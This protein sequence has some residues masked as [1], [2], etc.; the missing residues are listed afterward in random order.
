MRGNRDSPTMDYTQ[1]LE[2]PGPQAL[3]IKGAEPVDEAPE[4]YL[5]ED[6]PPLQRAFPPTEVYMA[7]EEKV[8][9]SGSGTVFLLARDMEELRI[10]EQGERLWVFG[11]LER[12]KKVLHLIRGTWSVSRW[13]IDGATVLYRA[14]GDPLYVQYVGKN[15]KLKGVRSGR[16]DVHHLLTHS[17]LM[18]LVHGSS[19]CRPVLRGDGGINIYIR[20]VKGLSVAVPVI[21]A[22]GKT[23]RASH[24]VR[25][26]HLSHEQLL[27]LNSRG[28]EEPENFYLKKLFGDVMALD[29]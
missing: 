14:H 15:L 28:V 19:V 6:Y 29:F 27:Y 5:A 8:E 21:E 20:G 13:D 4:L 9:V 7:T 1:W 22:T 3:K 10:R 2:R 18:H 11:R 24:S 16:T 23:R 12:V 26:L 17:E 25:T